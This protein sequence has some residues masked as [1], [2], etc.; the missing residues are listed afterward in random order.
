MNN[1][2]KLGRLWEALHR[3]SRIYNLPTNL[4]VE[5]VIEQMERLLNDKR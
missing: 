3:R 5:E 1:Y 4:N 2:E